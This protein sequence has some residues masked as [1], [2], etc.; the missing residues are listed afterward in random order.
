MNGRRRESHRDDGHPSQARVFGGFAAMDLDR[1]QVIKGWLDA[2]GKTHE[3]VYDA[4]W[5]GRHVRDPKTGK[6]PAAGNT[7]NVREATCTNRIGSPAP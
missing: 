3:K 4:A 1:P 5:S 7:V 2:S 6:L